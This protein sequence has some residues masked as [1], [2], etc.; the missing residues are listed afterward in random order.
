[1]QSGVL[2]GNAPEDEGV[3][4]AASAQAEFAVKAPRGFARRIKSRD[5]L[6]RKFAPFSHAGIRENGNPAAGVVLSLIHI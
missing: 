3:E 2:P 4:K 6:G 5:R 1:M